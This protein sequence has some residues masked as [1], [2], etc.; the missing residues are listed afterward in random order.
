[1]IAKTL[2][3]LFIS[4][5]LLAAPA[6]HNKESPEWK[7]LG[8][9]RITVFCQYCNDPGGYQSKSGKPLEYGD[10]AMNGVPMGSKIS[11]EGEVFTVTDRCGLNDT[12]DIFIPADKG[13]CPCNIL[14]CKEVFI[15][16]KKGG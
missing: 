8:E 12:V 5:S 9:Y 4:L 7:S 1:M 14:D 16:T 15:Q 3:A 6:A 2:T 11:I 13:Y 10:V